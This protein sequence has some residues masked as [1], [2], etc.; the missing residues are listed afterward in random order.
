MNE[1]TETRS[2]GEIATTRTVATLDMCYGHRMVVEYV[3]LR[4][5]GSGQEWNNIYAV[6]VV[7]ETRT[8]VLE[9]DWRQALAIGAALIDA[10]LM[11]ADAETQQ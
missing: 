6:R 9:L 2:N 10:G 11:A 8:D 4:D 7:G 1:V 3:H 5:S